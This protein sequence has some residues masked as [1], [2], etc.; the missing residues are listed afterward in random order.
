M[1]QTRK[2]CEQVLKTKH[3]SSKGH[4]LS[5]LVRVLRITAPQADKRRKDF[6]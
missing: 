5:E 2:I 6:E 1:K 3:C 4:K